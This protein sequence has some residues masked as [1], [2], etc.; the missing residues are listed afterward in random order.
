MQARVWR[1]VGPFGKL[2]LEREGESIIGLLINM[3]W[4]SQLGEL[5]KLVTATKR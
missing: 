5:K 3:F 4:T 1:A 2:L